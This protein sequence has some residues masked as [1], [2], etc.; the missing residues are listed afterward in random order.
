MLRLLWRLLLLPFVIEST[1]HSQRRLQKQRAASRGDSAGR[2]GDVH[3][4]RADEW[5]AAQ[6]PSRAHTPQ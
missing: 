5:A 6:S 4:H 1:A 3:V 2:S